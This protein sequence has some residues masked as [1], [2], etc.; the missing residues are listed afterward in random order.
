MPERVAEYARIARRLKARLL[1]FVI[2]DADFHP[3]P[4]D[5][6]AILR[7]CASL[8]DGLLLGIE[9]HDRFTA[10]TLRDIIER[11]GCERIGVCLDTANSLGA[12]EGIDVVAA[13]LAPL[14]LNLHIKDFHI[15]RVP[16]LMGFTVTGRPAGGGGL[17]LPRLLQQLAGS[18]CETAVLELWTPPES[19]PEDT[20][21]K[22]AAWATRSIEYLKP[23][24]SI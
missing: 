2:D 6:T 9:N 5:V 13:T 1:R 19:R 16:Y 23:F 17:N 21:D 20:I 3:K 12:G 18:R 22:E 7:E 15:A 4:E 11:A 10:A 14:V 24:F 8:L